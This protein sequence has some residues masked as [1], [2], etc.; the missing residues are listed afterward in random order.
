M[1]VPRFRALVAY[2]LADT[3]RAQRTL[4]PAVLVLALV[5][6]LVVN[7]P[8]PAPGP[9]PVTVLA[10]Y[11]AC[12]WLGLAAANTEDPAQRAV[13]TAAAGGSGAVVAATVVA[14]LATEAP[15]V[16]ADAAIPALSAPSGFGAPAV[17][18]ALLAHLVAATTGTA[19]GL[20]CA[21]PFVA[22]AGWAAITATVLVVVTATQPW[23][24]PVGWAV[25]A[26]DGVP[27]SGVAAPLVAALAVATLLLVVVGVGWSA[28]V[29]RRG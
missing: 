13:T 23:L 18:A 26:I 2:R 7:D 10:L 15:L 4:L 19:V 16:V 25:K 1:T 22:R 29:H 27:G 17:G 11:A 14:I 12:A 24:P 9:W 6:V 21:R 5:V 20:A 28:A 8:S 3:L